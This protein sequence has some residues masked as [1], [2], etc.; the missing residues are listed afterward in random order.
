MTKPV[1]FGRV[2]PWVANMYDRLSD[3]QPHHRDELLA[4]AARLVP[5]ARANRHMRKQIEAKQ[6]STTA[7][8][9]FLTA[10]GQRRIADQALSRIGRQQRTTRTGDMITATPE[11][12]TAWTTRTSTVRQP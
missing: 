11:L 12:V 2:E 9:Y 8:P 7:S 3:G 5:P 6:H 1:K 4:G 10:T